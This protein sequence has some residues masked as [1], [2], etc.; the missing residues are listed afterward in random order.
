MILDHSVYPDINPPPDDLLSIEDR[1][2]YVHRICAAFDFGIFP[3][4]TDWELFAGWKEV[5]DRFP[6]TD[7]PGWHTFRSWY[8]WEPAP[9]TQ[10]LGAPVWKEE[11]LR[12]GRTDPCEEMV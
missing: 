3:E 7:S 9:H 6:M 12:E 2:D 4:E 8:G 1:M 10:R 5:F 11:D